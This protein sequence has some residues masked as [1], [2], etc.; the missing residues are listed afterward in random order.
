LESGNK[1]K[2]KRNEKEIEYHIHYYKFLT[3]MGANESSHPKEL[4]HSSSDVLVFRVSDIWKH[5]KKLHVLGSGSF[6]T[7]YASNPKLNS[8]IYKA[9]SGMISIEEHAHDVDDDVLHGT[10]LVRM[11]STREVVGGDGGKPK[12]IRMDSVGKIMMK[13]NSDSARGSQEAST[14]SIDD[15]SS[16][17]DEPSPRPKVARTLSVESYSDQPRRFL[18]RVPSLS[19]SRNRDLLEHSEDDKFGDI[20]LAVRVIQRSKINKIDAEIQTQDFANEVRIMQKLSGASG[21]IEYY[22]SMIDKTHMAMVTGLA[23]GGDL[24]TYL[25]SKPASRIRSIEAPKIIKQILQSIESCHSRNVCHL[26]IKPE[27]FLLKEFDNISSLR[28]TD[29]GCAKLTHDRSGNPIRYEY[30]MGSLDF[31]APEV[32]CQYP[33]V[34]GNL[35]KAVDMW[36]IGVM[37]FV[38]LTGKKPFDASSDSG[39]RQNVFRCAY[40]FPSDIEIPELAKDFIGKL[41]CSN[42]SERMIVDDAINHPWVI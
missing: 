6:A 17:S 20:V 9:I 14:S 39:I 27:N 18:S 8:K 3:H 2:K 37:A 4:N 40:S 11:A 28:L 23:S 19:G 10:R 42:P 38:I 36:G 32:M 1:N 22:G 24:C 30:F 7:V 34:E 35:L 31:S 15:I 13:S 41:L 5:F 12:F 26:D 29:F 25:N 21:V 16:E 33:S